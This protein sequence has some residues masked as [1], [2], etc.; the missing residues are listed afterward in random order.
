[1]SALPRL[2]NE[3]EDADGDEP[4]FDLPAQLARNMVKTIRSIA[5]FFTHKISVYLNSGWKKLIKI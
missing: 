5:I 3:E 2:L 4:V 1:L